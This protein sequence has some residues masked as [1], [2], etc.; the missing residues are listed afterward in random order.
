MLVALSQQI[1]KI[2]LAGSEIQ[3]NFHLPART[4][5]GWDFF[6]LYELLLHWSQSELMSTPLIFMYAN[7]QPI[8]IQDAPDLMSI[9]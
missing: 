3:K 7:T 4:G 2:K 6:S 1:D 5:A 8:T 9:N